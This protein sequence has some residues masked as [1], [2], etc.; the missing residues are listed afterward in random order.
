MQK[1]GLSAFIQKNKT[2]K[3]KKGDTATSSEQQKAQ[4]I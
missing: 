2:K 3:E 4:D 1:K